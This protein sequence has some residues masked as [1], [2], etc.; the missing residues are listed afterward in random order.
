M[1]IVL[2][3]YALIIAL[4]IINL[5]FIG[6][7]SAQPEWVKTYSFLDWFLL[8]IAWNFLGSIFGTPV[9][10]FIMGWLIDIGWLWS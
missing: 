10:I 1:G 5:A 4:V 3:M 7:L 2:G 9:I 8:Y 6:L